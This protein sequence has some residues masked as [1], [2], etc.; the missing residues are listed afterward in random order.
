MPRPYG[1]ANSKRGVVEEQ[2]KQAVRTFRTVATIFEQRRK[3]YYGERNGENDD[4]P[5]VE[6]NEIN[7]FGPVDVN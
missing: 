1:L 4:N 5:S 7:P 6:K 3:L 2:E